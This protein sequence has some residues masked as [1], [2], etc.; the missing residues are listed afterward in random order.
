MTDEEI[1]LAYEQSI[2]DKEV[3]MSEPH[4]IP[5]L[6]GPKPRIADDGQEN[7]VDLNA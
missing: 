2:F 6:R 7:Q 4:E 1:Q 3:D 5:I